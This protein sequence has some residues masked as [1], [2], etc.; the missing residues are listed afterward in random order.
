MQF[1][2]P[3]FIESE[4]KIIGDLSFRQ[5]IYL[6]IPGLIV[7][8]LFNVLER[9]LWLVVSSI[10]VG[11]GAIFA[12]Q[13]INGQPALN[14]LSAAFNF[15]LSPKE[16]A[17]SAEITVVSRPAVTPSVPEEAKRS[18]LNEIIQKLSITRNPIPKREIANGAW[19]QTNLQERYAIIKKITGEEEAAKRID[20]R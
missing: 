18:P 15:I 19:L 11:I 4:N 12:F 16:Y 17:L 13:K 8:F 9:W 3:Q 20:Y 6:V 14:F 1:Q 5:F 7:V 2:V 10:T